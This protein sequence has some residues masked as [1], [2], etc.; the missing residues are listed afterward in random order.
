M[1][2]VCSLTSYIQAYKTVNKSTAEALKGLRA[3]AS[4]WGLPYT[5][6]TD[7]G[8]S[9]RKSLE[10]ELQKLGVNVLHSSAYNPQSMG[11][12]E[13]TVLTLKELLRKKLNLS[14]LQLAELA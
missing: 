1:L 11:L 10:E 13:R 2:I 3:W 4:S 5:V 7:S 9:F 14:Q 6:K 12:V 8:P